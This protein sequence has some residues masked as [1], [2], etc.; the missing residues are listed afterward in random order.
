V[1]GGGRDS[2]L[3]ALKLEG[4]VDNLALPRLLAEAKNA[5][6]GGLPWGDHIARELVSFDPEHPNRTPL[7]ALVGEGRRGH[8]EAVA[9]WAINDLLGASLRAY[10]CRPGWE[11]TPA[12]LAALAS[13]RP[14][15]GLLR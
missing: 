9:P 8:R 14:S 13:A 6:E 11:L 3:D 7:E 10:P 15:M 5:V 1:D 12:D 2:T 4:C